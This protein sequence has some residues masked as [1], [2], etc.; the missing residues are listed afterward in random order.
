MKTGSELGIP[1]KISLLK[2]LD[3]MFLKVVGAYLG[4]A[5]NLRGEILKLSKS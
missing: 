3:G 1:S 5:A 2:D 4:L